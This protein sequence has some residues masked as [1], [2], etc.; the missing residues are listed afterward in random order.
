MTVNVTVLG[1]ILTRGLITSQNRGD[2]FRHSYLKNSSESGERSALT[3]GFRIPS[4]YTAMCAI[5]REA[6]R[7]KKNL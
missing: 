4:A 3:L 5:Q 6:K 1:S 7:R 2:N